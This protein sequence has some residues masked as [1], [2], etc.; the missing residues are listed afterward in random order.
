MPKG[1]TV[2]KFVVEGHPTTEV[3]D[4][5]IVP[6]VDINKT[7]DDVLLKMKSLVENQNKESIVSDEIKND[8]RTVVNYF[9]YQSYTY[10]VCNDYTV[11][12]LSPDRTRWNLLS[13]ETKLPEIP[14]G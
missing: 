1:Y 8:T 4:G 11:W 10:A 5:K 2:K 14:Q 9:K 6:P 13:V 3:K 7:I 12:A